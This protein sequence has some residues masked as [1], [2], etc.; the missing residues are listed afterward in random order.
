MPGKAANKYGP[1]PIDIHVGE[2]LRMARMIKNVSQERLGDHLG[3]T[4]QQ[5]QKYENGSNRLS[6]SKLFESAQFLGVPVSFFFEG[7]GRDPQHKSRMGVDWRPSDG[8]KFV[9]AFAAIE[10]ETIRNRVSKLLSGILD[11]QEAF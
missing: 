10:S 8:I 4:F 2:C 3:I 6:S 9:M 5:I 11:A 7:L 1:H